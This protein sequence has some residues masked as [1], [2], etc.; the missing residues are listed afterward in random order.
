MIEQIIPEELEDK[1]VPTGLEFE[2]PIVPTEV[3]AVILPNI[4]MSTVKIKPPEIK[5]PKEKKIVI[6]VPKEKIMKIDEPIEEINEIVERTPEKTRKKTFEKVVPKQDQ[7]SMPVIAAMAKDPTRKQIP[8]IPNAGQGESFQDKG[9]TVLSGGTFIPP[10]KIEGIADG[11]LGKYDI[12]LP[13]IGDKIQLVKGNQVSL[14]AVERALRWLYRNQ[15]GSGMWDPEKHEGSVERGEKVLI[16]M[17][18]FTCLAY[19]GAGYSHLPDSKYGDTLKKALD[20]LISQQ[21]KSSGAIGAGYE[22]ALATM[23]LCD[24][25]GM[26][27]DPKIRKAASKALDFC[28]YAQNEKE[29]G[30]R[31]KAKEFPDTSVTGWYVMALKMGLSSG[32]KEKSAEKEKLE[33]QMNKSLD[34]IDKCTDKRTGS[35]AYQPERKPT[36]RLT[37]VGMVC[38]LF[39]GISS[40]DDMLKKQANLLLGH[41]PVWGARDFYYWYYGTIAMHEMGGKY[42]EKWNERMK[43]AL[44]NNQIIGGEKDG[45]WDHQLKPKIDGDYG[46]GGRIWSTSGGALCLEIYYRFSKMM[47]G[48]SSRKGL[49][50]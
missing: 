39:C 7:V 16:G 43:T 31:Y 37:A 15:E 11:P 24:A 3:D 42:W 22:H 18:A 14:N 1:T 5:P 29:G 32:V 34:W 23:A 21:N 38:K 40:K 20:T 47:A 4:H 8:I 12:E 49:D 25:Y 35:V 48:V 46:T 17:T 30:W 36:P 6:N 44:I 27:K 9:E 26:V 33:K 50:D 19:T 45:S 28:L 13:G 41:T 10:V 2:N